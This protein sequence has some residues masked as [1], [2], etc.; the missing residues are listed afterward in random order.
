M[1]RRVDRLYARQRRDAGRRLARHEPVGGAERQIARVVVVDALA[2]AQLLGAAGE[3]RRRARGAAEVR[4]CRPSVNR[5]LGDGLDGHAH[6]ERVGD[7][8]VAA[9]L[10]VESVQE[11]RHRRRRRLERSLR[12]AKV[13]RA[14]AAVSST[15]AA[16]AATAPPTGR[17]LARRMMNHAADAAGTGQP[18]RLSNEPPASPVGQLRPHAGPAHSG[19]RRRNS[20][21]RVEPIPKVRRDARLRA[22][23]LDVDGG[24]AALARAQA[25]EAHCLCLD[26][27]TVAEMGAA[28]LLQL[29][30]ATHAVCACV[31]PTRRA[32]RAELRA[33]ASRRNRQLRAMMDAPPPALCGA[34]RRARRPRSCRR[35][36]WHPCLGHRL[37]R[38][39]RSRRRRSDAAGECGTRGSV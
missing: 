27:R 20:S 30:A 26:P 7:D 21:V 3:L 12:L 6:A 10:L 14:R 25:D 35:P 15:S 4:L 5:Q 28:L 9:G 24:R 13:Q 38:R 39:R 18:P 33:A 32:R 19:L 8:S 36:R 2:A 16:T 11:L 37:P 31:P 17:R 1:R 29:V 34:A 22:K 23:S